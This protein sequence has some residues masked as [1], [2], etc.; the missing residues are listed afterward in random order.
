MHCGEARCWR[1]GLVPA[2]MWNSVKGKGHRE[3]SQALVI[4]WGHG[5]WCDSFALAL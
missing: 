5:T 3:R 4:T 2:D 1:L